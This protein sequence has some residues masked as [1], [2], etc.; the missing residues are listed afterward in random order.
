MLMSHIVFADNQR[1]GG[2]LIDTVHNAGTQNPVDA[3]K[4]IPAMEQH[5][6][7]KR[8]AVM[9]RRGMNDHVFGLVNDQKIVVFI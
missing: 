1:T 7:D 4:T 5:R 6:I 8:A 3:G 9:S 2:I